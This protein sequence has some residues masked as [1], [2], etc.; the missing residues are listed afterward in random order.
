[1]M[2]L[3]D[4]C[5]AGGGLR[6]LEYIEG[7]PAQQFINTQTAVNF[8]TVVVECRFALEPTDGV[9]V[10]YVPVFG[11]Y[12]NESSPTFRLILGGSESG[13]RFNMNN[14][15]SSSLSASNFRIGFDNPNLVRISRGVIIVN[16]EQ[17]MYSFLNESFTNDNPMIVFGARNYTQT[18]YLNYR[19]RIYSFK[20]SDGS[21]T[22][23][24][25][26][27]CII[28]NA[29]GMYDSIGERFFGNNGT[30]RFAAGPRV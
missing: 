30:G 19:T 27:P 17:R 2:F 10:S 5:A 18:N 9:H 13:Y 8:S 16:G 11:N 12:I 21:T 3:R 20:I 28:G 4:R 7:T 23:L 25:L 26:R 1:M 14:R 6:W 22:I 29:V 24:D 15:A